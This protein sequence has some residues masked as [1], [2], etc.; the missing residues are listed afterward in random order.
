MSLISIADAL[1]EQEAKVRMIE[2]SRIETQI[3]NL[4]LTLQ[5]QENIIS[6]SK[7]EMSDLATEWFSQNDLDTNDT[8]TDFQKNL[9]DSILSPIK[10]IEKIALT[11]IAKTTAKIRNAS[12][13]LRIKKGL[14][15]NEDS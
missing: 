15:P 2:L 10:R 7:E 14:A 11:N 5:T 6:S 8:I 4:Y 9:L 12:R 3:E 1:L 13:R